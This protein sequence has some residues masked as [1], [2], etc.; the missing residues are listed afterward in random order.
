MEKERW[1]LIKKKKKKAK[2]QRKWLTD[3]IK[4]QDL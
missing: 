3:E 1:A 4:S 2:Q